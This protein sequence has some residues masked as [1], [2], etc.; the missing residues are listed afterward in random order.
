MFCMPL[1]D[2]SQTIGKRCRRSKDKILFKWCGVCESN[3]NIT[4]LHKHEF[5]V[6]LKVIVLWRYFGLSRRIVTKSRRCFLVNHCRCYR[7][8]MEEGGGSSAS[9]FCLSCACCMM[10]TA[11]PRYNVINVCE[12]SL[13]VAVV[14]DLNGLA[15]AELI[16]AAEVCRI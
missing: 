8:C 1:C 15:L 5:L 11:P 12:V 7:L 6:C 3:R 14:E 13:A 16:C 9:P 10:R 2:S 4:V